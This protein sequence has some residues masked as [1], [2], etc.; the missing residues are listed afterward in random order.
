[1]PAPL[2]PAAISAIVRMLAKQGIK[3]TSQQAAKI[4]ATR[5]DIVKASTMQGMN[6]SALRM[7]LSN[8]HMK[9]MLTGL[10]A[11]PVGT[12]ALYHNMTK[13]NE[14]PTLEGPITEEELIDTSKYGFPRMTEEEMRKEAIRRRANKGIESLEGYAGGGRVRRRVPDI[15]FNKYD[16]GGEVLTHEEK[17]R[18]LDEELNRMLNE[19]IAPLGEP[20]GY[21]IPPIDLDEEPD[22]GLGPEGFGEGETPGFDY[23]EEF[24]PDED[25]GSNWFDSLPDEEKER[26]DRQNKPYRDRERMLKE[27]DGPR[28]ALAHGGAVRGY[29]MGGAVNNFNPPQPQG[30]GTLN[31]DPRMNLGNMQNNNQQQAM[32]IMQTTANAANLNANNLSKALAGQ[33]RQNL[34]ASSNP[35]LAPTAPSGTIIP[36]DKRRMFED[37]LL[38][39]RKRGLYAGKTNANR[40]TMPGTMFG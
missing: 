25:Y 39:D 38:S 40:V 6:Q 30:I 16:E 1:M 8:P 4:A 28:Q 18:R 5:P 31:T 17:I 15:Y 22:Y 19:P 21:G 27:Y 23:F 24:D 9:A 29:N 13:E 11:I 26:I 2:A 14:E 12:A 3:V 37:K 36:R 35:S 10:G 7:V 32:N 34:Q 33:Q 20:G